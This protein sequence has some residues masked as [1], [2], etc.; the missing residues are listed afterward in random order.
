MA[1]AQDVLEQGILPGRGPWGPHT[2]GRS[3]PGQ[4]STLSALSPKVATSLAVY[5][6]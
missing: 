4:D 2:L 5:G 1:Q 6:K 3:Q